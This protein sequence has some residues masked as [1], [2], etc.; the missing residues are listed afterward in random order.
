MTAEQEEGSA[1]PQAFSLLG[2][3]FLG[4]GSAAVAARVFREGL[5]LAPLNQFLISGLKVRGSRLTI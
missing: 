5:A 2:A 3:A 4:L 1:S